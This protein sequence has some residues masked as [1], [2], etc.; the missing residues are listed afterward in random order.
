MATITRMK[1][2]QRALLFPCLAL[3]FLLLAVSSCHAD[4][5]NATEAGGS[6]SAANDTTIACPP[7]GFDS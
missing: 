6:G 7:E 4:G 2:Q 3:L 5:H 1:Q